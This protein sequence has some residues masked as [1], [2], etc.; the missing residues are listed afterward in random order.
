MKRVLMQIYVK[1]RTEAFNFYKNAFNAELGYCEKDENGNIIHAELDICG[2]QIAVGEFYNEPKNQIIGN[3]MQFC[4]QF[5]KGEEHI[6]KRA[7]EAMQIDGKILSPL[8]SCFFS[9]YMADIID[10]YG[11]HWCLFI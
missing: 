4:L 3:T 11:V 2:Q 1:D 10:K 5:D 7:Y 8:G 6:I 9:P